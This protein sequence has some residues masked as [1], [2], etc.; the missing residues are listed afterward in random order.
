MKKALFFLL[1]AAI[2]MGC[3]KE[4]DQ[5]S[6]QKVQDPMLVTPAAELIAQLKLADVASQA[7][8]E[9]LRVA[10]RIDFDEQRLA[11]IGA[12]V[13]GRVTKID[14]LLGQDVGKGQVLAQ[15]NS[16][17]ISRR[18]RWWPAYPM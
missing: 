7:V 18:S 8:A 1:T 4:S 5:T 10:G 14:A 15:L 2:L 3:N 11:R 16:R 6:A 17:E 9:T 12:T 13:T